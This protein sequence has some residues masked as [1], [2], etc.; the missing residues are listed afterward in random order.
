MDKRSVPPMNWAS[1][2]IEDKMHVRDIHASI[3]GLLGI[4]NMKLSYDY[5]GRPER[6]TINEGAL[7]PKADWRVETEPISPQVRVHGS[8]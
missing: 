8:G 4:D 6:P 5:N 3:L 2:A 1:I 7:K